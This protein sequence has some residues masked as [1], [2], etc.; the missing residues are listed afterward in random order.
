MIGEKTIVSV[1][2]PAFKEGKTIRKV[3]KE[4][5]RSATYET[6]II[7]V[8]G[9][10][11]DGTEEIAKEENVEFV[12]ESRAGYG[13]A[14]RTGL[15]HV[16][17]DIIVIIDADDTYEACDMDRLF[18]PLLKDEADV[19]LASRMGGTL[20]PGAMPVVNYVGNRIFTWLYSI[21][22]RQQISDTQTGF[23][24]ITKRALGRL[25]LRVDGMG[26]STAM[27]T[28]A[29]KKG[30]RIT[31]FPTTYKPRN[32]HSKSKLNKFKA[33]CEIFSIL[34]SG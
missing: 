10:S 8:D 25:E 13:R 29:A 31:E 11:N 27:L 5:K 30:L 16:K 3:I 18:I 4:I 9:Y 7:I 26:I 19:C 2:I 20:L 28:E 1:V 12:T 21:M 14:I 17:G 15:D 33:G 23:R 32:N 24:A 22:Y 34:L 6:Q